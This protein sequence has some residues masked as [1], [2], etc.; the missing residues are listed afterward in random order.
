MQIKLFLKLTGNI[1]FFKFYCGHLILYFKKMFAD[2]QHA[3]GEV[4]YTYELWLAYDHHFIIWMKST[5]QAGVGPFCIPTII[6]VLINPCCCHLPHGRTTLLPDFLCSFSLKHMARSAS[7]DWMFLRA[8][9]FQSREYLL[10]S[11]QLD[12]VGVYLSPAM[13]V[14]IL[15]P[16][17]KWE[18]YIIKIP[19]SS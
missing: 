9:D 15:E 17:L 16:F 11:A 19:K 4:K 10:Q 6:Y 7:L 1:I 8:S 14:C 18:L 13:S 5:G 3:A 2:L 12:R